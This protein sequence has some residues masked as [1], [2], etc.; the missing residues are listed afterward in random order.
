MVVTGPGYIKTLLAGAGPGR[1][2]RF[3]FFAAPAEG[4]RG[5]YFDGPALYFSG[6]GWFSRYEDLDG[7]GVADRP[8]EN[9]FPLDAGEH[10]GHP[11][12]VGGGHV[13][14]PGSALAWSSPRMA[15]VMYSR[16]PS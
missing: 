8:P 16:S 2:D 9:L 7:D 3:T 14:P 11:G 1:A 6:N 10:G 12:P 5:M 15:T 4:G 13:L